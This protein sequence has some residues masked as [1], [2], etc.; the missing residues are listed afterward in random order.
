MGH[1]WRQAA[2]LLIA[3][4]GNCNGNGAT[5]MINQSIAMGQWQLQLQ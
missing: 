4:H 3:A 5:A 2:L 1:A